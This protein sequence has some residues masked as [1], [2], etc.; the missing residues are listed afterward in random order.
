MTSTHC[1]DEDKSKL[2]E[3][4]SKLGISQA[5][6]LQRFVREKRRNQIEKEP[7]RLK[8]ALQSQRNLQLRDFTDLWDYAAQLHHKLKTGYVSRAPFEW[9]GMNS[10]LVKFFKELSEDINKKLTE[11]DK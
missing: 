3:S 1:N 5:E 6:F 4:I 8:K 9:E 7:D 10:E 2:I 11:S